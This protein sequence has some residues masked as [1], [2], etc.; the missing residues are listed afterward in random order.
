M[1]KCVYLKGMF[2]FFVFVLWALPSFA[3]Q[4]DTSWVR[5]Y[6][7]GLIDVDYARGL[8]LDASGNVYVTGYSRGASSNLDYATI[9]YGPDGT[10]LWVDR[11]NGT[12]NAD[13][14]ACAIAV[15]GSGNIAVTGTAGLGVNPDY[16]TIKYYPGGSRAWVLPLNQGLDFACDLA[17]DNS[18]NVCVTGY[19]GINPGYVLDYLT[20]RH[21][22]DGTSSWVQRFNGPANGDDS[23][24]AIAVDN[25]GNVYV[26]GQCKIMSAPPFDV[27]GFGTVKYGPS[28]NF[29]WSRFINSPPNTNDYP[30]DITVDAS[31]NI[32]VTG[33]GNVANFD[34]LTVKYASDG[35]Q[36]WT[37]RYN[38]PGNSVDEARA[39][40]VDNSGNVYVTGI[41]SGSGTNEDYATI[42][43]DPSGNQIWV[44]RYNGPGN[45]QDG[46]LDLAL[47]NS[48]NIYV[49]G[50][51]YDI[52][53]DW[54]YLTIKYAA[55][56]TQ[57]WEKRYK[58]PV[59]ADAAYAIAVDN[60]G[61]VYVT[62]E[63]QSD[64]YDY[65][66]IKYWQNFAPGSFSLTSPT[67]GASIPS[68]VSFDW[69]DA[70][71]PDPWDVVKY[72]LYVSTSPTFHADSTVVYHDLS[73]SD[74]YG[75][76]D[77][78]TYYWKVKAYDNHVEVWSSQT[79][80]FTVSSFITLVGYWKFEEGSGTTA[81][82]SSG[83]NNHGTI[84]GTTWTDGKLG[85][86]L[87][88]TKLSDY[89]E[90]NDSP[91]LDLTDQLTITAW[92]KPHDYPDHTPKIVGKGYANTYSYWLGFSGGS[93]ILTLENSAGYCEAYHPFVLDEWAYVAATWDGTTMHIYING[94][95]EGSTV[96]N[97]TGTLTPN[98]HPL[99]IGS[100][101]N[102]Y[103]DY[104]NGT[105][106]EV[107]IYNTT[108]SGAEIREE[109]ERGTLPAYWKFDEG[110]GTTAYDSSGNNNHGTL[111]GGPTSVD[112]KIGK[113]LSFDGVDDYIEISHS[114][115]LNPRNGDFTVEAWIRTNMPPKTILDK[116]SLGTR[117]FYEFT[118]RS[119]P[120]G[121]ISVEF[122]YPTTSDG[123]G[124]TTSSVDGDWHYVAFVRKGGSFLKVYMDGREEGSG[125]DS[126]S[127]MN[128]SGKL[129]VGA[130]QNW[131]TGLMEHF[132]NGT[133]DEVKIYNRALSGAEIREEYGGTLAAYWKFD[134]GTG[135]IAHDSSAFGNDGTLM[136]EPTWVDGLPLL[137]KALQFDTNYVRVPGSPAL[138]FSNPI[139][140]M[141]WA[142]SEAP[143]GSYQIIC[144]KWYNDAEEFI[145]SFNLE[146]TPDGITPSFTVVRA[147]DLYRPADL[148]S[149]KVP[150]GQ[151]A[152]IA[153]TYD[154]DTNRI[155][156]NGVLAGSISVPGTMNTGTQPVA[157]GALL[158]PWERNWFNG[159]IDGVKIY[160]RVL[161]AE[162]IKAQFEAGFKRGDANYDGKLTVS[163]VVYL[164]NYLFKGGPF[165]QPQLA[166]DA[167][168]DDKV[169]V[170]DVV[171][172]INYLFKGGPAP[173]CY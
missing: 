73:T 171:Y 147:G 66:T 148:S 138:E 42:K 170:S 62:G 122:G 155:Y 144:A 137:G 47:D 27:R 172:L 6:D 88:F 129:Y 89:V 71:D 150:S 58:G 37:A 142:K 44:Q 64:N 118:T 22:S 20:V 143:T 11:Y 121:P 33:R 93:V 161:S 67:S 134:E 117:L 74:Y 63:S 110:T 57:L 77:I 106:D 32:Y 112:G 83:N 158:Y 5:R 124:G 114:P 40:A 2:W 39:V 61:N 19:N 81:Y 152:H 136:N 52:G 116:S 86:G 126:G 76:F 91:I 46:A 102:G 97:Y 70:T 151:W 55:D 162:E 130:V 12:A 65:L 36:N 139:T 17:V 45:N 15:D 164:I 78:A 25:S 165:P 43:Y 48:G 9:K 132:W 167:N 100:R 159:I 87:N 94:K 49:T 108:L 21:S 169:T 56:G 163:D 50:Y 157:I 141:A 69:E 85:K 14:K 53:G 51:S 90:V 109:Y 120:L 28:G 82:D 98:E 104:F 140:V 145:G 4:V 107:K 146:F 80:S 105:I 95:D 92:I 54:D 30:Y 160:S 59:L 133:I 154:N 18:G 115:L 72:D 75:D 16:L 7:G 166:G 135:S 99:I 60:S 13:D 123:A 156:V 31:G 35:T 34:Y 127:D 103:N 68:P 8:A 149:I 101:D 24:S 29:V 38:G 1:P 128:P 131:V 41:S 111:I 153:G 168:C 10:Q 173:G 119:S 26:T 79:W 113:A 3:Q 96:I 23:A 125:F 84:H